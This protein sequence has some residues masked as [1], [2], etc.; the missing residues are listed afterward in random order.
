ME[1]SLVPANLVE[2]LWPQLLPHFGRAAE[3]TFGRYEPEDIRDAIIGGLAHLWVAIGDDENIIGVTVTRFWQYPRK[4]CLDMVFIA[5]DE[6]FSW[7]DPMLNMLQHW[8]YDNGCEAIESSGR[9][10]FA[11]AFRDDGYKL[12]WQVYELPVAGTGLGGQDG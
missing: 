10:G 4:K 7:K 5:G 3:Y 8:A 11:R 12:L 6:G 1:V 9:P 2:D